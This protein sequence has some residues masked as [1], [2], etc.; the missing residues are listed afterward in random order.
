MNYELMNAFRTIANHCRAHYRTGANC[1]G[2]EII[3]W[4]EDRDG[5]PKDLLK[6]LEEK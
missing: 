4:C 6:K 3:K 1:K 5:F 2:C